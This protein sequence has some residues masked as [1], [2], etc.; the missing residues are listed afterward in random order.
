MKCG[1]GASRSVETVFENCIDRRRS[2]A[3]SIAEAFESWTATP[4]VLRIRVAWFSPTNYP[5]REV[6]VMASVVIV[7]LGTRLGHEDGVDEE[8]LQ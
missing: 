4:T 6:A 5:G 2:L 3:Y 7:A 1:I 8:N